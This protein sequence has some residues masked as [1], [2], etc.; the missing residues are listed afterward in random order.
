MLNLSNISPYLWLIYGALWSEGPARSPCCCTYILTYLV[1]K[2]KGQ[3]PLFC[4]IGRLLLWNQQYI[5]EVLIFV[6]VW[7]SCI[8][9]FDHWRRFLSTYL[10]R[11]RLVVVYLLWATFVKMAKKKFTLTNADDS[12][13]IGVVV[14]SIQEL[15]S[16]GNYLF[17][18]VCSVVAITTIMRA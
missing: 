11:R 5:L 9:L 15:K 13:R 16:K 4:E 7:S 1:K 2:E 14:Y 3:T 6:I 8:H 18:I 17:S 12:K 10:V